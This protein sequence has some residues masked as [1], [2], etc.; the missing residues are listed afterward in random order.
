M[1]IKCVAVVLTALSVLLSAGCGDERLEDELAYRQVGINYM[2]EG[3]YEKAVNAFDSALRQCLGEITDTEIDICYYKAAAQSAAGDTDGAL[4]TY[5]ALVDYDEKNGSAYYLRGT[6]LLAQGDSEKCLEDYEKAVENSSGD[7]E[8]YVKIYENLAAHNL[9]EEGEKYL[10][11]AFSIK[12]DDAQQLMWRG[13]IY[14]LLGEYENARTELEAAAAKGEDPLVY[15][16][17]AQAYE[18][19]GDESAAA[20]YYQMYVD[21]GADD[22]QAMNALGEIEMAKGNYAAAISYFEQGL[23]AENAD[24]QRELMQ[25]CIAAYEYAG[26]F[27]AAYLMAQQYIALYPDDDS[28]QREYIFLSTR[29]SAETQE[30]TEAEEGTEAQ[31]GTETETEAGTE[32]QTEQ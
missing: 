11:Q 24:N 4:E 13:R 5:S 29:Q 31:E 3:E 21:S 18:A 6:L 22:S 19:Q 26:D 32:S 2:A 28:V 10:N 1:K 8:L 7:Y 20:Q 23:S 14:Y 9:Q 15:F 25:N 17:L 30:T 12:G 16:Y 27:S